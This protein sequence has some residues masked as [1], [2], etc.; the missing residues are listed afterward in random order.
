MNSI[1]VYNTF[2]K[3]IFK[4][5]LLIAI[6]KSYTENIYIYIFDLLIHQDLLSRF[7][8]FF[9]DFFVC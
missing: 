5:L 6:T 4:T 7:N 8:T 9:H 2:Y 3:Q 1:E